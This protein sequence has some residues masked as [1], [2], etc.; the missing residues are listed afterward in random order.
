MA[1]RCWSAVWSGCCNGITPKL[2]RQLM[3]FKEKRRAWIYF[4]FLFY[5]IYFILFYFIHLFAHILDHGGTKSYRWWYSP[6]QKE[7]FTCTSRVVG[8]ETYV[9]GVGAISWVKGVGGLS[10]A[11]PYPPATQITVG[12]GQVCTNLLTLVL[13]CHE[14]CVASI[15]TSEGPRF[16]IKN[17]HFLRI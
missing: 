5:F 3:V 2:Y 15:M 16:P 6:L 9:E 17:G 12:V 14:R 10:Q 7:F 13:T 1:S 4:L 11:Y 8:V